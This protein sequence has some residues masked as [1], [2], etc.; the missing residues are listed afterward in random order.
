MKLYYTLIIV[1]VI[2][3]SCQMKVNDYKPSDSTPKWT[4]EG[5]VSDSTD[6][7]YVKISKVINV[8]ENV[9]IPTINNAQVIV[10][11]TDGIIDTFKLSSEGIYLPSK[12]WKGTPG[13]TYN[14]YVSTPDI[15]I[16]G[17]ETMP[18][19]A[20]FVI[21]SLNPVFRE[22]AVQNRVNSPSGPGS[23]NDLFFTGKKYIRTGDSVFRVRL[24]ALKELPYR[25]NVFS[26]LYRNGVLWK[27][28]SRYFINNLQEVPINS[29]FILPPPGDGP[30]QFVHFLSGDTVTVLLQG[31][32]DRCFAYYAGLNQVLQFDGGLFSSPAGNPINN[33]NNP[34]VFGYFKVARIASKKVVVRDLGKQ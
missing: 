25:V 6:M 33:Y 4:V 15:N 12:L 31:I 20:N 34:N 16:I 1:A 13:A 17:S 3:W 9:P 22:K 21:D 8:T 5:L 27:P 10:S 30:P 2:L 14:L 32:T 19:Y 23:Y 28:N 7:H 29:F 11:G 26:Y 18:N 24:Y